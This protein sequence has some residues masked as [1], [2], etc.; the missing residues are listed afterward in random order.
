[1][2]RATSGHPVFTVVGGPNGAGKSTYMDRLAALGYALG[3]EVNPDE[4]AAALPGPD[5][6]RDAS[7][8]RETLRRTRRLIV[9]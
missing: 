2:E 3:E 4:I 5:A 7:A 8:G 6:T 1:M 9:D